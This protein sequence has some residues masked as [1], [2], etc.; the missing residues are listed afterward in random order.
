MMKNFDFDR[1]FIHLDRA[2][3]AE[4]SIPR[5]GTE[6]EPLTCPRSRRELFHV[7]AIRKVERGAK[8]K[9]SNDDGLLFPGEHSV[10][11]DQGS[12]TRSEPAKIV[13]REPFEFGV[14]Q[15]WLE[16]TPTAVCYWVP[17]PHC[18]TFPSWDTASSW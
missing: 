11:A 9:N 4:R 17:A 14:L 2:I 18:P 10:K 15:G 8:G 12:R 1:K 6:L 13:D 7:C 3:T 5:K 16:P